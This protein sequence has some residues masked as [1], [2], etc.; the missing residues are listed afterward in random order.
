MPVRQKAQPKVYGL[1]DVLLFGKYC[2][3]T[4]KAIAETDPDYLI[5]MQQAHKL[6]LSIEVKQ[7]IHTT[8]YLSA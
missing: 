1:S 7:L 6:Q 5:Y 3:R 8:K 2:R 4:L